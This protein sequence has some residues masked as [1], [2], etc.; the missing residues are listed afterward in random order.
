MFV[1]LDWQI[2]NIFAEIRLFEKFF[3]STSVFLLENSRTYFNLFSFFSTDLRILEKIFVRSFI[4]HIFILSAV[5]DLVC[6]FRKE[7]EHQ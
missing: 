4:K 6:F 3:A 5:K 2:K 1:N 7:L